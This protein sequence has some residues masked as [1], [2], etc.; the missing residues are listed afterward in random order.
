MLFTQG[1]EERINL[2][3]KVGNLTGENDDLKKEL[4]R[5]CKE[6]ELLVTEINDLKAVNKEL[7]QIVKDESFINCSLRSVNAELE[8]LLKEARSLPTTK[9][10]KLNNVEFELN[11]RID[12]V[13]QGF[14][15]NL[16]AVVSQNL[17]DNEEMADEV[18]QRIL[19][20]LSI[21]EVNTRLNEVERSSR[22]VLGTLENVGVALRDVEEQVDLKVDI[23]ELT[24]FKE[25]M[26]K[27]LEEVMEYVDN[28]FNE[29]V[30]VS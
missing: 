10:D 5:R 22:I 28:R 14:R 7:D 16:A 9:D 21:K 30:E 8:D 4:A 26:D 20:V 23:E 15:D 27:R 1:Q 3:L 18:V 24:S 17:K 29:G 2:H 11:Q 19:K 25:E 13:S 12:N 6:A